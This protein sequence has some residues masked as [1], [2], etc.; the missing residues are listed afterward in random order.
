MNHEAHE[1]REE[2]LRE[3]RGDSGYLANAMPR[4][5]RGLRGDRLK[6]SAA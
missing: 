4:Y 3:F 6:E 1:D 2:S 5:L